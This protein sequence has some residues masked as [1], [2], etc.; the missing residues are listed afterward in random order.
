MGSRHTIISTLICAQIRGRGTCGKQSEMR[1]ALSR[2]EGF[3]SPK[4]VSRTQYGTQW[5]VNFHKRQG[6][7]TNRA[8]KLIA[9]P[10]G[11]AVR[12]DGVGYGLEAI[13]SRH[14]RSSR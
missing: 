13:W 2:W 11:G 14:H 5:P 1:G 4:S 6:G 9:H 7:F 10:Q 3:G 12:H 8:S